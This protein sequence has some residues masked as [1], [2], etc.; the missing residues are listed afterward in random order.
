MRNIPV[1]ALVAVSIL[2][3][4]A[5]QA[6]PVSFHFGGSVTSVD[7]ALSSQFAMGDAIAI[8]LAFD[9][10]TPDLLHDPHRA[11]YAYTNFTIQFGSYRASFPDDLTSGS[12]LDVLDNF[13]GQ[14]DG[15]GPTS[16][17]RGTGGFVNGFPVWTSFFGLLDPTQTAFSD[18]ALPTSLD[19][20][21][22]QTRMA[23]LEFCANLVQ[24]SCAGGDRRDVIAGITSFSNT[25]DAVPEPG[26]VLLLGGTGLLALARRL[27]RLRVRFVPVGWR[28][29]ATA[30]R[31][32]A[33]ATG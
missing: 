14:Y 32:A 17:T 12:A 15:F 22:F 21:A 18:L 1:L 3:A 20:T 4:R 30:R 8:D 7:A 23:E 27:R 9:T 31:I 2:S 6:T 16:F 25:I 11:A 29:H 33:G 26:T 10:A 28:D 19:L 5:A 13:N 24:G